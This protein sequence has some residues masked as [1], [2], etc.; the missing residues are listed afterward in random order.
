MKQEK[1]DR[2]LRLMV[3]L[4]RNTEL[5]VDDLGEQTGM[6]R[7]TIYRYLEAFRYGLRSGKERFALSARSFLSF[8]PRN[9]QFDTF[10]Y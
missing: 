6:S 2:Q 8:F 3:L 9:L 5:S 4:A 7:R 10:H 1:F